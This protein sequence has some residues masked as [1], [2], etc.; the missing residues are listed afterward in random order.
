VVSVR[1]LL[2]LAELSQCE[3]HAHEEFVLGCLLYT[4][5]HIHISNTIM[6]TARSVVLNTVDSLCDIDSMQIPMIAPPTKFSEISNSSRVD[7]DMAT[8]CAGFDGMWTLVLVLLYG[9]T[10][11]RV[12]YPII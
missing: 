9:Q 7:E 2:Y 1:A 6:S 5:T 12:S 10:W 3:A 8:I 11:C 4:R